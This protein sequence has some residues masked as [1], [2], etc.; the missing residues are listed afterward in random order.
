MSVFLI[1]ALLIRAASGALSIY[2]PNL[3]NKHNTTSEEDPCEHIKKTLKEDCVTVNPDN[4]CEITID[5]D[6]VVHQECKRK[7]A[8]LDD[9][10]VY[11]AGFDRNKWACVMARK[12]MCFDLRG[13]WK[14]IY[15]PFACIFES[16]FQ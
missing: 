3:V 15:W 12:A 4:G 13:F 16:L 1:I 8:A 9:S 2:S 14:L 6:C 11:Y 7:V 10:C 5:A